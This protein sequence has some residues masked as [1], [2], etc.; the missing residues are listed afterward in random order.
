[1]KRMRVLASLLFATVLAGVPLTAPAQSPAD[2]EAALKAAYAKYKDLKLVF[3][4]AKS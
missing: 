4:S 3:Y 1:M 2:V